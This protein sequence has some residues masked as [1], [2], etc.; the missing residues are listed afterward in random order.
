MTWVLSKNVLFRVSNRFK[1]TN[2]T[3]NEDIWDELFDE[4]PWIIFRD[5][6]T[7]HTYWGRVRKVSD[8]KQE[9]EIVLEEVTVYDENGEE[10]YKM[11]QVYF[12]RNSSE[13]S[14]E[15]D[16]YKKGEVEYETE[17]KG[18]LLV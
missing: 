18:K 17:P 8:K 5:Y 12:C 2:R 16:N 7:K 4:Q 15:I 13:F 3:D 9:R 6:I 10:L 14:I 11:K 1:I